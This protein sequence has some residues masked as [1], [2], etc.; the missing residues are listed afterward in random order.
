VLKLSNV[1]LKSATNGVRVLHAITVLMEGVEYDSS[2]LFC[3]AQGTNGTARV[4]VSPS[5]K[6]N[7]SKVV[8]GP[9]AA[10]V[11]SCVCPLA[12]VGADLSKLTGK[13]DGDMCWNTNAAIGDALGIYVY[14]TGGTGN[15]WKH[16][17][18]GVTY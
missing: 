15:G 13:Q 16:L 6:F 5:C 14:R 1:Y 12:G 4:L 17:Y 9:G 8:V 18:S 10:Q 11:V 3:T 7:N 2:A